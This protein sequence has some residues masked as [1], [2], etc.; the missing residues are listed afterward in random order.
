MNP[1]YLSGPQ[2]LCFC[3]VAIAGAVAMLLTLYL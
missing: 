1:L 2:F 3:V